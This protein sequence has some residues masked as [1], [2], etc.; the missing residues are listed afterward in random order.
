MSLGGGPKYCETSH[1]AALF[2]ANCSPCDQ[3]PKNGCEVSLD[4]QD[5]CGGCGVSCH[6]PQ[7]Q[8]DC[9]DRKCVLVG[10]SQGR[11]DCNASPEDG[12]EDDLRSDESC[13]RCGHNCNTLPHVAA[14]SC[15]GG[16]CEVGCQPNFA[17][18]DGLPN[19]GCEADLTS[20]TSC[21]SCQ[22]DC[23]QLAN[24]AGDA[25]MSGRCVGLTCNAGFGDCNADPKDGCERP[26]NT[27]ND[28]GACARH[29]Q[30]ANARAD[31]SAGTCTHQSCDAGYGDCDGNIENGCESRLDSPRHCGGCGM[32][33]EAGAPCK[34]GKCGCASDAQCG[35]GESCC[36]NECLDTVGECFPFPC[37]P[38]TAR[39]NNYANCGGCGDVCLLFCCGPLL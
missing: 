30:P 2:T 3:D 20:A 35:T 16:T 34:Q 15:R 14:G 4:T 7:G 38:G 13:G 12:C 22:N 24:V 18:C 36:N 23:S 11:G 33:C 29:C 28:C 39:P 25:C 37:I 1:F 27:L 19:N 26:L 9:R 6:F 31:C 32:A 17:D 8:A 5:D 10:C 21:G